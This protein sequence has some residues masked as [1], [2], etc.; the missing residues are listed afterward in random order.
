MRDGNFS[1]RSEIKHQLQLQK[2][3]S[4]QYSSQ[5]DNERINTRED[6]CSSWGMQ[7]RDGRRIPRIRREGN[8]I[9][10][11]PHAA[12]AI[13]VPLSHAWNPNVKQICSAVRTR[14]LQFDL[15]DSGCP[16]KLLK[17]LFD[18]FMSPV[19]PLHGFHNL[20][21]ILVY[22]EVCPKL[23]M[24]ALDQWHRPNNVIT[25]PG[26]GLSMSKCIGTCIIMIK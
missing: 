5:R 2:N 21:H 13:G 19:G 18:F 16:D 23:V 9:T 1:Q 8:S 14:R 26:A 11:S 6:C 20:A 22:L 12:A 4:I 24:S 7:Y 3:F 10:L 25:K 17:A 15:A